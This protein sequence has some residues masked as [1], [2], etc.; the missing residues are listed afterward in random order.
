MGLSDW[1]KSRKQHDDLRTQDSD[2]SDEHNEKT[3]APPTPQFY[4]S[5]ATTPGSNVSGHSTPVRPGTFSGRPSFSGS[6]RSL[7][8]MMMEDIKHEV[9]VN[10][11]FQQ[12]C[13]ALWVGDGSGQFEGVMLRKSKGLYMSCPPQLVESP[14]GMACAALNVQ[15]ST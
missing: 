8:S 11:L 1:R 6:S 10:Y 15:V 2:N 5:G 12:Q 7:Q 13:S 3:L 14:F 4:P 9:M